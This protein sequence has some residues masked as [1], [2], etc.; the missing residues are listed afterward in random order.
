MRRLID[1]NTFIKRFHN[2]KSDT[3]AQKFTNS[4]IRRMIREQPTAYDPDKVLEQ[5]QQMKPNA[6]CFEDMNDY[7]EALNCYNNMM[8]IVN[9]GGVDKSDKLTL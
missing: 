5:L 7:G 3:K 2:G 1:A 4:I 9:A 8:E 6:E